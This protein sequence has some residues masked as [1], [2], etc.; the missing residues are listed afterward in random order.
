MEHSVFLPHFQSCMD[1]LSK[2]YNVSLAE[3]VEHIMAV[4]PPPIIKNP[5]QPPLVMS[6]LNCDQPYGFQVKHLYRLSFVL[7]ISL[8]EHWR[9]VSGQSFNMSKWKADSNSSV[10]RVHMYAH[11]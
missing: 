10:K 7:Q 9:V 1:R 2:P 6:E 5:I 3:I 11:V 8:A 4:S